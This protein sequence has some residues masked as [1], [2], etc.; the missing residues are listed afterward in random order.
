M[1]LGI[2]SEQQPS[3]PDPKKTKMVTP[4]APPLEAVPAHDSDYVYFVVADNSLPNSEPI[5]ARKTACE[6]S[7]GLRRIVNEKINCD[8]KGNHLIRDVSEA[9]FRQLIEFLE[10]KQLQMTDQNHRLQMFSVAKQYN[11]P[12]L[13]IHCLREV[14]ANL[15][16]SNVLTVYRTLWFYGS[17]TSHKN[18]FDGKAKGN[19]KKIGHT[20]DEYLTFWCTMCCNSSI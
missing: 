5:V 12:E 6:A 7:E 8:A 4:S 15:N 10:T 3:T 17:L 16:V 11:C 18:P 1:A 9:E 2:P 14:D 20:P 13:M 19:A